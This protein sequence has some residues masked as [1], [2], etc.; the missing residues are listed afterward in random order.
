MADYVK[1]QVLVF[2]DFTAAPTEFASPLRAHIAGPQAVLHR[3][4]NVDEKPYTKLGEY[5]RLHDT[6]YAW[7]QRTA[8]SRV[9][10]TYT[11]VF[12]D[13]A[14]LQYYNTATDTTSNSGAAVYFTDPADRAEN[15]V[16]K[17]SFL[18]LKS[19]GAAYP[20]SAVLN[21]RDVKVG[22][23]V[24]ATY[25]R[26]G[27]CAETE[28]WTTI[29]GFGS[30]KVASRIKTAVAASTNQA[31]T[32]S[33]HT[34]TL[35]TGDAAT[36]P[37]VTVGTAYNGWASGYI[38]EEY[39]FE[40][41]R[42]AVVGCDS[43]VLR[44]LSASGSDDV[45]EVIP[46][47]NVAT[48][49][50]RGLTVTFDDQTKLTIGQKWRA[51]VSQA[52]DAVNATASAAS[53]TTAV[54]TTDLLNGYTGANDDVY[55]VTCTKGGLFAD[56]P[57]IS[58]TT[59]KGLDFSGPTTVSAAATAVVV[60]T[61]GV[62][63]SFN[64]LGLRKGDKWY[65][66]CVASA[67]GSANEI[68]LQDDLPVAMRGSSNHINVEFYIKDN[69]T[70]TKNRLGFAPLTN[71]YTEA[72]QLCLQ[73]GAVAYHPSWTAN[74][75]QQPLNVYSGTAY[76]EY[77]EWLTALTDEVG[78]LDSVANLDLIAG[79]L[80]P[81]NPLKWGVYKALTNS[82]GISVKYTAVA[83]PDSLDSWAYVLE[84]IKGRDDIYN[85]VPLTFDRKVIDLWAA[86]IN[87]E[88]NEIAD[89]WK[90]GFVAVKARPVAQVVGKGVTIGGVADN[91]V[92]AEVLATLGDDP[93]A[94]GTQ[95]TKL[96]VT[97]GNGYFITNNVQPG[98][99]VRYNFAVD[100]FNAQAYEEYVVDRVL[101][102]NTLLLYSGEDAPV[103]VPQRVEIYHE[104][105][106]TEIAEDIATQVG[107]LA[108]R[109]ICAVWPDEVG[110]AGTVQPG[111]YLAAALAGLASGVLGH[112]PLTNVEVAGF[113][114]YTRSYK[115]FN[116]TQLNI[117]AAAGT[118]IVTQ[119]NTG[120]PYTRQALTTSTLDVN[121]KEES[122]RRNVDAISYLFLRTLRPYIGRTNASQS[123]VNLL[124]GVIGDT[125]RYLLT[126]VYTNELGAPITGA[127]L[128]VLR[129]H[130]LL[131][132]RIEIV[133]AISVPAPL[134]NIELH[135]VV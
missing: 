42:S 74:G 75:V 56:L 86:H 57:E 53:F 130:P 113:D 49:G 103:T 101:S 115:Y 93:A 4:T 77:R 95:Y 99:K 85:L 124:G 14:L 94:T 100:G 128:K 22:D 114:D 131:K 126:K 47:T 80:D 125:A 66:T 26:P 18:A 59:A 135:L 40:V 29:T 5:N 44:V 79:Q 88:S 109:R 8:G 20:R 17:S 60:G 117:I 30:E 81:D 108:N 111:Y 134:N 31:T 33:T 82:N 106:R 35:V 6:F 96:Q 16:L 2:Q 91:T 87:S 112:Q 3:Y 69:I 123:M 129:L 84:R 37:V 98:D 28:L 9:D 92:T 15:N 132:D 127:T 105:T 39:T 104:R 110:E 89:N 1:P 11:K 76:V 73:E 122:I 23:V 58:V 119:S 19:N 118:W 46:V 45:D 64:G 25:I 12:I 121:H 72:T 120:T 50:T 116:E 62:K 21:D 24:R 55:I 107:S 48:I 41:V 13:G 43:A 34:V 71:Y 97:S 10:D 51:V 7:P 102:E 61:K 68:Y 36:A 67:A 27:D 52:F 70:L 54:G 83:N 90:G 133:L 32:A 38:N 63:V 65:I 78:T